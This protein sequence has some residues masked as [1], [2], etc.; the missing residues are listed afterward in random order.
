MTLAEAVYFLDCLLDQCRDKSISAHDLIEFNE[1]DE[2]T[3]ALE[4]VLS[5]VGGIPA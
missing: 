1:R 4:I 2:A 5:H 3:A